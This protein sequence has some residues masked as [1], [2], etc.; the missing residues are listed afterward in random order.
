MLVRS[1]RASAVLPFAF[2]IQSALCTSGQA[3]WVNADDMTDTQASR[4]VYNRHAEKFQA[5]VVVTNTGAESLIGPL[6]LVV[7]D[8]NKSASN[9]DG[10]ANGKAYYTLLS[11]GETLAPSASLE[12]DLEFTGGRGRLAFDVSVEKEQA[13]NTSGDVLLDV[14][15]TNGQPISSAEVVLGRDLSIGKTGENGQIQFA[16]D[17]EHAIS[18]AATGDPELLVNVFADGYTRGQTTIRP[19][20]SGGVS[21]A[22]M[23]LKP[24]AAVKASLTP[25]T[26]AIALSATEGG[27]TTGELAIPAGAIQDDDGNTVTEAVT[28]DFTPLDPSTPEIDAFPGADFIAAGP[29]SESGPMTLET[30]VLAEVT[31]TGQSGKHYSRVSSPATVR[32]RIPS[33]QQDRYQA[34]DTIPT[35]SYNEVTGVWDPEGTAVITI[36]D[37]GVLWA[38]FT[39]THFTWWNVDRPVS[40][41][42]CFEGSIA[43]DSGQLITDT[44]PRAEGRSYNGTSSPRNDGQGH[45]SATVKRSAAVGD[46]SVAF[47]LERNGGRLYLSDCELA[48]DEQHCNLTSDAGRADVFSSPTESGSRVW[49]EVGSCSVMN[50]VVPTVAFNRPPSIQINIPRFVEPGETVSFT[51]SITD[52]EGNYT[53]G[54]ANWQVSCGELSEDADEAGGRYTTP[55]SIATSCTLTLTATDDLGAIGEATATVTVLP[56][57]VRTVYSLGTAHPSGYIFSSSNHVFVVE[58]VLGNGS[59]LDSAI[60]TTL[61]TFKNRQDAYD[62]YYSSVN[63]PPNGYTGTQFYEGTPYEGLSQRHWYASSS[64]LE[65]TAKILNDVDSGSCQRNPANFAGGN[66]NRNDNFWT[67]FCPR[68]GIFSDLLNLIDR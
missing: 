36:G 25:A 43:N 65:M 33:A 63:R 66:L 18:N 17:D 40:E 45:W 31:I 32:L 22:R 60:L 4:G 3:A 20:I 54:H 42:A 38:E 57:D 56:P 13:V 68:P 19:R 23:V 21:S 26:E 15:D 46:E 11:D 62:M 16:F 37:G 28:V 61:G 8:S 1:I 41:H 53:P 52:P 39:A 49:S 7:T 55:G 9:A 51:A 59:R 67:Y 24:V 27:K 29:A 35:W 5:G 48:D 30:V 34:G 47:F 14:V 44:A 58:S 2:F 10:L 12:V 50:I 64:L 6:R